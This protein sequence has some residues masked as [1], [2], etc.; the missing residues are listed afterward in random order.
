MRHRHI[1]S[2]YHLA[3]SNGSCQASLQMTSAL[4]SL[5]EKGK[6]SVTLRMSVPT[7]LIPLRTPVS[8]ADILINMHV[9]YAAADVLN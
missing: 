2:Q 3:L 8:A 9:G 4:E 7:F 1:R 6:M 5:Q